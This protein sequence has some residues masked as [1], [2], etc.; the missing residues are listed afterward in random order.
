[1]WSAE[2]STWSFGLRPKRP[3][4]QVPGLSTALLGVQACGLGKLWITG[5]CAVVGKWLGLIDGPATLPGRWN[6]PGGL[7]QSPPFRSEDAVDDVIVVLAVSELSL[8]DP[9][10]LDHPYLVKRATFGEI[11]DGGIRLDPIQLSVQIEQVI[12]EEPLSL[13]AVS[14]VSRLWQE[15][16]AERKASALGGWAPSLA[17]PGDIA[18]CAT[19]GEF[20]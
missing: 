10:L 16:D 3:R 18:N 1:M 2:R 5:K 20:D 12:D 14:V 7:A 15:C 13:C 8:S 19:I 11:V 4:L 9:A 17:S 6:S